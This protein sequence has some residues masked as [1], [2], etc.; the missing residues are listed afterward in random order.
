MFKKSILSILF[1]L[2]SFPALS[3]EKDRGTVTELNLVSS[4]S[5]ASSK[6]MKKIFEDKD[7][8]FTG[9]ISQTNIVKVFINEVNGFVIMMEN[10]AGLACIYFT[11]GLGVL[12]KKA[13]KSRSKING[14][15]LYN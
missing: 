9:M 2:I 7:I 13:E 4:V 15:Y 12:T 11:G 8:V 14:K 1:I 6:E 3:K 10:A 5:C